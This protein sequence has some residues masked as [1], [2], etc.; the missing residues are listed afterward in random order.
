MNSYVRRGANLPRAR[1][2]H[3]PICLKRTPRARAQGHRARS[4]PGHPGSGEHSARVNGPALHGHGHGGVMTEQARGPR[5]SALARP[6]RDSAR[7]GPGPLCANK[8]APRGGATAR[9]G[10]GRGS[11]RGGAPQ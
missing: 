9:E 2:G 4:D 6:A 10:A 8:L 5:A 7:G 11:K 1:V 3:G